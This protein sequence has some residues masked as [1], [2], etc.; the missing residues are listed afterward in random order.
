MMSAAVFNGLITCGMACGA[1]RVHWNL[2]SESRV[3]Q[4]ERPFRGESGMSPGSARRGSV[5]LRRM[6]AFLRA[7]GSCWQGGKLVVPRE[8]FKIMAFVQSNG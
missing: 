5:T 4:A 2:L 8:L 7:A 1:G 6:S 3:H